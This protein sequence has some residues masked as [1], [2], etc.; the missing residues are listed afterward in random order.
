M[1][2]I[3]KT[4]DEIK[5]V[6]HA[7]YFGITVRTTDAVNSSRLRRFYR[8]C[9]RKTGSVPFPT[10]CSGGRWVGVPLPITWRPPSIMY[11]AQIVWGIIVKPFTITR[12]ISRA[13]GMLLPVWE[14]AFREEQRES[15]RLYYLGEKRMLPITRSHKEINLHKCYERLG[16]RRAWA[17]DE[18]ED[19]PGWYLYRLPEGW[20]FKV[21]RSFWG[22]DESITYYDSD[23]V[24]RITIINSKRDMKRCGQVWL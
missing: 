16:F 10:W 5:D 8:Q 21:S 14:D 13:D 23:C 6:I 7:L 12:K 3:L 11:M 4:T 22:L 1:V 18:R 17:L 19:L 20:T 2:K 24:K 15:V 9:V